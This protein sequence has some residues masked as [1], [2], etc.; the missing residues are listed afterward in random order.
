MNI[1]GKIT[2]W[3]L[4]VLFLLVAIGQFSTSIAASIITL[5]AAALVTPAVGNKVKELTNKKWLSLA[6]GVFLAIIVSPIVTVSTMP[7]PEDVAVKQVSNEPIKDQTSKTPEEI[8]AEAEAKKAE[9]ERLAIER[10]Q[11]ELSNYVSSV[12]RELVGI[13]NLDISNYTKDLDSIKSGLSRIE[14]WVELYRDGMIFAY[15]EQAQGKRND[16]YLATSKKQAE[17]LPKLRDAFGPAARNALWEHDGSAKTTGKGFTTV[18]FV[19]HMFAANRNIK[20]FHT[21]VREVLMKLRFK[22]AQYRWFEQAAEYTYYDLDSP[23]DTDV[24]QWLSGGSFNLVK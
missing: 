3:V 11:Q 20:A 17:L 6:L 7:K 22:R 14:R 2:L 13:S 1:V 21:E 8:A 12:D 24:V 23:D 18:D 5:I 9:E 19:S 15:D 4:A 16:L 10:R